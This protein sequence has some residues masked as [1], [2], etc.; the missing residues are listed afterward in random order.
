MLLLAIE[1]SLKYSACGFVSEKQSSR[2][3]KFS[4]VSKSLLKNVLNFARLG[5]WFFMI[6]YWLEQKCDTNDIDD[7][8]WIFWECSHPLHCILISDNTDMRKGEF[9]N[10]HIFVFFFVVCFSVYH[11]QFFPA[12]SSV[13]ISLY[14]LC[15]Q[16]QLSVTCAQVL[17]WFSLDFWPENPILNS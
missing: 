4:S 5:V 12:E 15:S 14:A 7:S 3:I 11:S 17:L 1:A 9:Q 10:L 2:F 8:D 6:K 13:Y 16:C